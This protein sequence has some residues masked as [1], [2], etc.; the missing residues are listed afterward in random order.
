MAKV[1]WK[2]PLETIA[3]Q[4]IEMPRHAEIL[5]VQVQRGVPSLWA[6]VDPDRVQQKR[7]FA[8]YGTGHLMPELEMGAERKYIGTYQLADGGLVFH[9][10]EEG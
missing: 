9:V 7:H 4:A 10:F 2:F 1:I 3:T 6:V 5:T 8:I